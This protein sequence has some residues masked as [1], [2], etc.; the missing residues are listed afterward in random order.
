MKM[1]LRFSYHFFIIIG[2]LKSVF[3][4]FDRHQCSGGRTI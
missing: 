1:F 3:L 2:Y 4:R